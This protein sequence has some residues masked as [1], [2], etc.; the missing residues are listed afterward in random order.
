MHVVDC[1]PWPQCG[2]LQLHAF[3]VPCN[4]L[5]LAPFRAVAANELE[6]VLDAAHFLECQFVFS[7]TGGDLW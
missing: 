2:L 3:G 1:W 4:S 5:C 7:L 6:A